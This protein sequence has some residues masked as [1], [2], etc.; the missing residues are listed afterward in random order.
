MDKKWNSSRKLT[1]KEANPNIIEERVI[2][3]SNTEVGGQKVSSPSDSKSSFRT[4]YSKGK[5]IG[6]GGFAK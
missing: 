1:S 2:V 6:K 4:L 3:K 5:Q